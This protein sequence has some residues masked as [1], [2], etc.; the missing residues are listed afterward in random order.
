MFCRPR[1]F[2]RLR[3][4]PGPGNLLSAALLSVVVLI[5]LWSCGK[6]VYHNYRLSAAAIE[7]FHDRLNQGDFEAIYDEATDDFRRAGTRADEIKLFD[8]VH[9]KM[10]ISGKMSAQGFHINWRNGRLFVDQVY[11]TQFALG[12]AQ[13]SFVWEIVQD[14]PRMQSYRIHSP[15]LQ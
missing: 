13:E 3:N 4:D 9:H 11:E 1:L 15:N 2:R 8:M 5:I 12:Q 6:G 7:Q 14:Q 10:G